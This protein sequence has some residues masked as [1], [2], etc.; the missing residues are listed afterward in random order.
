MK[1]LGALLLLACLASFRNSTGNLCSPI[2]NGD[3][4]VE[5]VDIKVCKS[6]GS[7]EI[8]DLDHDSFNDLIVASETDSSVTILLGRKDGKFQE[9]SHSPFY[10]GSIPNDIVIRDFSNDG[11]LDLAFANHEKKYLTLLIGNGL[12]SFRAAQGSPFPVKGIPHT[13]GLAAG[14]FNNDN[15]LDLVTDSWGN[16]Q[17]EVLLGDRE[18][19]FQSETKFFKV[20]KRPYQ[21]LRAGDINNDGADDIVTTNSEGDN[22]TVLL[23]DGRGDFKEA[24]GSPFP[25]GDAPFGLGIGDL[26]KDGNQD[27]AIINSPGSMAEGKGRN[28]LTVLMGDGAGKFKTMDGSP[29]EAGKIPNRV[30]IGD[31]NGDGLNDI[32]TSDNSSDRIFLFIMKMNGT[33][34]MSS[35][36][37]VGKN[38]KGIAIADLNGDGKSDIVVCNQGD[39]S[40]S[41]VM[42]R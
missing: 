18:Q 1:F 10:A 3:I 11:N 42:S 31:V 17:V 6:P 32:A 4:S 26:N 40:I 14:H 30:A 16:D 20:G 9:A 15:Q 2:Q 28:G 8:A 39:D 13:H 29:F 21:R 22:V 35:R 23:G 38:P 5:I 27:L 36:M 33:S 41:I 7:V 24:T 12:G 19:F 34:L 25:C 37:Q